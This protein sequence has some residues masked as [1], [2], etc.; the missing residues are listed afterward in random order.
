MLAHHI[1]VVETV[2]EQLTGPVG[3][4][5]IVGNILAV[6][7]SGLV[8]P[9]HHVRHGAARDELDGRIYLLHLLG[10][11]VV[12][13]FELGKR[14]GAHLVVAPW[15]V[16]Y[17]PKLDVIWL[18]AAVGGAPFSHGRSGGSVGVF[19]Q[20][21]RRPCVAK[22]GIDGDVRIDTEQ[23][24][25]GEELIGAH[26]VGLHRVPDRIKD[27]R[28][29]V[30]LAH[31]ISPLVGGDKIAAGKAEDAK[32]QLLQRGDDLAAEALDVVGGHE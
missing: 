5:K 19:D 4:G 30:N 14:Y 20:L 29:L 7:A 31:A 9:F 12:L 15:L 22:T 17:T 26:V 16:A 18:R 32:A 1:D 3:R 21:S 27:G 6:D 8:R 28:A 25:E 23:A 24:T 10:E 11:E 2:E 13:Q